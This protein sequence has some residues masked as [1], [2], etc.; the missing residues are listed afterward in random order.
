VFSLFSII[1]IDGFILVPLE[2]KVHLG[3]V[4]IDKEKVQK[5]QLLSS[6]RPAQCL[7]CSS[8]CLSADEKSSA[9]FKAKLF[10]GNYVVMN[11][12]LLLYC[13]YATLDDDAPP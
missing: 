3:K 13:C 12:I 2:T 11:N 5:L 6:P 9:S 1:H 8:P 10:R 7:A 4:K